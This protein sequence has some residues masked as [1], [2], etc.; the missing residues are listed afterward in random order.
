MNALSP[1]VFRSV[2]SIT[3]PLP[4][5]VGLS[6][7]SGT[8]K[9]YTALSMARGIAREM[10]GKADANIG[11]VDTENRRALHYKQQ[12]PEMLHFDMRAVNDAGDMIGFPP[13]RWIEVIDAAEAS[14]VDVLVMDSFS[15]AW[16]GVN[17]VLDL[18]AQELN[19]ITGGDDSKK[20]KLGQL[21][22]AAIKPRYR[23]LIDRIVRAKVPV[24][25]CTRAKPVMQEKSRDTGWKE[26]NARATK[27]R[28]K[29]VPWDPASDGD[30]LFEMTTMVILDPSA[31]GH[32]VHQIKVADQF[33]NLLDPREPMGVHTGQKMAAWAK[34]DGEGAKQKEVLD[35]ARTE[36]RKG[37][38]SF[39][40]WWNLDET[41]KLR[42]TLK[43]IL[44]ALAD[45]A[46]QADAD[47][48]SEDDD[49]PLAGRVTTAPDPASAPRAL[50]AEE[51]D[52]QDAEMD[53]R[54]REGGE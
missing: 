2:E 14:G 7:G 28:R 12:F 22:W 50:T 48:A 39:R 6:G 43:P 9:T 41:K 27:T 11:F 34:G 23:R 18:Q 19:R 5:S 42:P 44:D 15:H 8:G 30:L 49:D 53:R 1:I 25:I 47:R 31:P 52:A 4:L 17:G 45:I 51:I 38:E 35:L 40:K 26:Q 29:D 21:A 24:I 10:T 20:N 36:A 37:S 16:E 3:E 46:S 33:K 32:P 13:E 54:D